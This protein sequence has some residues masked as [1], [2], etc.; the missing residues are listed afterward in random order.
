MSDVIMSGVRGQMTVY[1]NF[2]PYSMIENMSIM[3]SC[4]TGFGITFE[5]KLGIVT[6]GASFGD[7]FQ[8]QRDENGQPV[9]VH[10]TYIGTKGLKGTFCPDM[11]LR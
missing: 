10:R 2:V 7:Y 4:G 5:G 8:P 3:A 11:R 1:N 9:P 6:N